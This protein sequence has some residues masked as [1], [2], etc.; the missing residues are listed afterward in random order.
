MSTP[1]LVESLAH[2]AGGQI[3]FA[4][5]DLQTGIWA[6]HRADERVP[7]A[8]VIK[9]PMLVHIALAVDEGALRWDEPITL[10][11]A[12]KVAGSGILKELGAGLSLSLRDLCLLMTALS[13]N[14]ATNM[15]IDR[16]GIEA[17]NAR[18]Q[19]LGMAQTRLLRRAFSPDTP[20]SIPFGLGVTTADEMAGLLVKIARRQLGDGAA[21]DTVR[22]ILA[23]QQDRAGIPR[24]LPEGWAYA[25]KTG[26]VEALRADAGVITAPDGRRFVL[27]AFCASMPIVDWTPD[28]PGLLAIAR[29]AQALLIPD[30]V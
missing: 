23:T 4:F 24:M 14:T 28:N 16:V 13:D 25:G 17:I 26:A 11:E 22:D 6:R 29:L 5:H 8:S 1:D 9:L 27:A 15:L 12:V 19:A 20:A 3:A 18:A 30:E 10:A 21:A 2:E 7:T